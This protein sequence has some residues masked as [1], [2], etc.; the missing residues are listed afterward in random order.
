MAENGCRDAIS[1]PSIY[2]HLS[3]TKSWFVGHFWHS[4]A[5][6]AALVYRLKQERNVTAG[7]KIRNEEGFKLESRSKETNNVIFN[8]I[9]IGFASRQSFSGCPLGVLRSRLPVCCRQLEPASQHNSV[10]QYS[11][12]GTIHVP[13][14]VREFWLFFLKALHFSL[15][16]Q[17]PFLSTWSDCTQVCRRTIN[18]LN[19]VNFFLLAPPIDFARK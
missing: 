8:S 14:S 12:L 5:V 18:L 4:W 13:L 2:R 11:L 19:D 17:C 10:D 16:F 1:D 3:S 6:P 15:L 7:E 9:S